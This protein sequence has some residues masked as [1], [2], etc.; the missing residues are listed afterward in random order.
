MTRIGAISLLLLVFVFF[1]YNI[2]W[3]AAFGSLLI[4]L[5]S[6]A[7]WPG[8]N[9]ELLGLRIPP[10][11]AVI[12]LLLCLLAAFCAWLV[13]SFVAPAQAIQLTP[14]WHRS[15]WVF[16]VVH[17]L[18]QTLN[19]EMVLGS[20]L[21]KYTAGRLPQLPPAAISILVGL[22]FSRLHYAF[23][24][25]R[26]GT[27]I[28]YGILSVAALASIF[29]VGVLRNNCILS[30]GNIAFAWGI[31]FG[32][33]LVFMDSQYLHTA[34]Q[35]NLSEPQM[36]NTV[37]GSPAVLLLVTAAAGLSFLLYRLYS[38]HKL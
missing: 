22:A 10:S 1:T 3:L 13:I 20:L 35:V 33:N 21:L 28:N 17:T 16:L 12:A 27:L 5:L 23:Y 37:F 36:F 29:A 19:E 26:P 14:L 25:L 6:F 18:G 38:P 9:I 7:A 24:G 32:W 34:T 11:Q 4:I 31:H 30:T 8:R 2:W 15:T